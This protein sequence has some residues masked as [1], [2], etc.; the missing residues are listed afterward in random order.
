MCDGCLGMF[1][2][3]MWASDLN[4]QTSWDGQEK[5]M[6]RFNLRHPLRC[7]WARLLF[8]R[9]SHTTVKWPTV[10]NCGGTSV[11]VCNC[12]NMREGEFEKAHAFSVKPS[13][14]K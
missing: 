10:I 6:L 4:P 12:I 5:S 1:S 13:L 11:N 14:D 7:P 2:L 3:G 9:H 8:L